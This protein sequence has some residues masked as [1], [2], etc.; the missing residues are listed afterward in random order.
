MPDVVRQGQG[1]L[2]DVRL[3]P[4]FESDRLVYLSY[5]E[6]GRDGLAGTA[7][8]RGRWTPRAAAWSSS[9]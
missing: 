3:S 6:Q 8:G 2:L 7:V 9:R 4:D 5:A 1:G